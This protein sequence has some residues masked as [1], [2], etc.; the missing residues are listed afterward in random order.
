MTLLANWAKFLFKWNMHPKAIFWSA[1][2]LR[3]GLEL[4]ETNYSSN[5]WKLS[6]QVIMLSLHH[7]DRNYQF[8]EPISTWQF[9]L[10]LWW[11]FSNQTYHKTQL[12][13][14]C[15]FVVIWSQQSVT[16]IFNEESPKVK[17]VGRSSKLEIACYRWL[18]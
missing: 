11:L 1:K 12:P 6:W 3:I 13:V 15:M 5:E 4:S 17:F 9:G 14:K 18:C 2:I 16:T 10:C 7:L 8:L